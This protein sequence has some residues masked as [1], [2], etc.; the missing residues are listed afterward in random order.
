MRAKA[1]RRIRKEAIWICA[2]SASSAKGQH[3]TARWLATS[4]AARLL[5]A[6]AYN[7]AVV[8]VRWA[9]DR[10]SWRELNAEAESMLRRGWPERDG[11]PLHQ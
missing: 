5:A 9:P 2:L 11:V 8:A 10:H 6:D 3:L 7:Y 4:K 1:A